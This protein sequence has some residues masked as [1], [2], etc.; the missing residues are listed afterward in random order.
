MTTG[1]PSHPP[2]ATAAAS[3][4]RRSILLSAYAVSPER[5][6]EPGLGWQV[7]TR[8]A[9]YH[10]VTVLCSPEVEG[11]D[12]RGEIS[13]YAR[14]HGAVAGLTF[15][16]VEPPWLSRWLQRPGGSPLR[17][18][19]YVGY[20]AW[21]R[22]AYREACRLHA[23]VG[24]DL[25]HQFNLSGYREPGYLWRLGLPFVWGPI[26]GASN[27]PWSCFAGFPPRE[28]L[29]YGARNLV[30][31]LHMHAGPTSRRCRRAAAV[32]RSHGLIWG[33]SADDCRMVNT[34]WRC[35]AEAMLETGAAVQ[36]AARVRTY[37]GRRPLRLVWSGVHIGRK[38]LPVLLEALARLEADPAN[39]AVELVVLGEGP[40]TPRWQA[41]ARRL[42]VAEC[43]TWAGRLP[44]DQAMAYVA[45]ADL[46]VHTS[47]LE[48]T[49]HAVIEALSLGVP[50]LC[51][52]A[53]GMGAAVDAR[54]GGKVALRDADTSVQGFARWVGRLARD[55]AELQQLS[56]G[57][58]ARADELS[59][60]R[61][62]EQI[63]AGY[64]T[65][66]G[67]TTKCEART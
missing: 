31:R 26:G 16:Y 67:S 34:C 36:P 14:E 48:G 20:A 51:H 64:A 22:A 7:A 52:D 28:R 44:R 37:D 24:F 59:W 63:V 18:L 61:K 49:P 39:P 65:L 40:Q 50:V 8:L 13:A 12:Y 23:R 33:I 45:E 9:R 42:G 35:P 58:L 5:G 62:V 15:H 38:A 41:L 53:C 57:A 60:D 25:A 43:V 30:N 3:A 46:F 55:P 29:F 6:S 56:R 10:D 19:Y 47:L 17:P 27:I 1:S 4:P 54:C 11:D 32:A 21:Q 66:L 2:L